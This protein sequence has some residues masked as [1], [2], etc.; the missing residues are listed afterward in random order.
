MRLPSVKTIAERLAVPT[1]KAKRIRAIMEAYEASYPFGDVA[2]RITL[3]RISDIIDGFG[4]EFI[5]SGSNAK[6]PAIHYVN[7]G[8]TYTTTVLFVRGSFQIG[9]WGSIVER[10]N[11]A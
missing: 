5:P 3:G 2:P 6:S 10:G 9:D 7:M 1:D 11:Y 8:D 4:Y